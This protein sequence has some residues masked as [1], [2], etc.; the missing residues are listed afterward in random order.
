MLDHQHLQSGP[1]GVD[2]ATSLLQMSVP[3]KTQF[4]SLKLLPTVHRVTS[5]AV[6]PVVALV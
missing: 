5:V 1:A 3:S 4:R 6:E 2:R